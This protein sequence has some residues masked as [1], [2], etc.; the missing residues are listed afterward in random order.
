MLC[1]QLHATSS[2]LAIWNFVE[3]KLLFLNTFQLQVA[4]PTDKGPAAK[5]S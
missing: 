1:K 2:S 4:K 5:E 3:L